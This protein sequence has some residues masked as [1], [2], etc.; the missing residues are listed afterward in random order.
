MRVAQRSLALRAF[1]DHIDSRSTSMKHRWI[2]PTL[3]IALLVG[4]SGQSASHGLIQEPASRNW[5]CG[6]ITK[7]DQV[8]NGTAAYPIC[9]QAFANDFNGGYSFMSVLTHARGRAVVSPL[10]E[11]VCGFGSETWQG[12]ATPWDT[13]INWPTNQMQSGRNKFTWNISWGPHFDDTEEFRYWI[14]KPGFQ[15]QVG[16]P[17]KWSDFEE[18]PFCSLRYDDKNPSASPDV[19]PDK[20]NTQFNTYCNVPPRSGRHVIYGEWG[21]NQFTFERFHSCVD[22]VFSGS[23]GSGPVAKIALTPNVTQ[24]KGASTIALSATGSTGSALQYQ[25]SVTTPNPGTATLQNATAANATLSLTNPP[26]AA[27]VLISLLVRNSSGTDTATATIDHQPAAGAVWRDLGV[28]SATART[29]AAGDTVRLRV[30]TTGGQ[31]RYFPAA[32]LTLTATNA[33][34]AAWP[35]AL[36][37]AVNASTNDVRI[38]VL[39][40]NDTVTPTASATANRIYAFADTD[41]NSGFVQIVSAPAGDCGVSKRSGASPYW[42]GFDAGS[43]R[44]EFVLDFSAT[45]LDLAK[46]TVDKGAFLTATREGQLLRLRKPGWVTATNRGYLGLSASNYPALATSTTPVCR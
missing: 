22:A 14:T 19:I 44:E 9:G 30:V 2:T 5:Y 18:Q 41:I 27:N 36:A 31:D 16:V 4:M 23:G 32:P 20:P 38:G 43:A 35:L 28:V 34:A 21:R 46:V 8:A 40:T 1:S 26:A 15:F 6:A 33:G 7:P 17:L 11:H 37:N 25:W 42:A 12:R 29:L 45:G 24:V 39:G 13:P 3:G 10:P